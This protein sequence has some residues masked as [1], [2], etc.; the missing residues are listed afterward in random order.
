[1]ARLSTPVGGEVAVDAIEHLL[2]RGEVAGR[3]EDEE[4]IR[5]RL[6]HVQ[7]AVRADVVDARVGAGV[8]QEDERVLEPEGQAVGHRTVS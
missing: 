4:P 6:D 3:L 2:R 8:G 5:R 1:M 7:L